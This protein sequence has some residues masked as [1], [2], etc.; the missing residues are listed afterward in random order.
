MKVLEIKWWDTKEKMTNIKIF[1]S[2][3]VIVL[4]GSVHASEFLNI[5]L[6]IWNT[7]PY[8]SLFLFIS[9]PQNVC[10]IPLYLSTIMEPDH[11]QIRGKGWQYC[12]VNDITKIEVQGHMVYQ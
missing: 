9:N 10:K 12:M 11:D 7:K 3:S 2:I 6:C 4:L 5:K 8:F 1:P